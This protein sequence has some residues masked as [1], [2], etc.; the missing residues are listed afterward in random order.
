MWVYVRFIMLGA[1][2]NAVMSFQRRENGKFLD[3]LLEY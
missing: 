3:S 2:V 1:L